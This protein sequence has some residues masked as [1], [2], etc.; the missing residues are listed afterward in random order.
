MYFC[1]GGSGYN[2]LSSRSLGASKL[3]T[4]NVM[5]HNVRSGMRA[6]VPRSTAQ[7]W[8]VRDP[9]KGFDRPTPKTPPRD[10]LDLLLFEQVVDQC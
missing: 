8:L 1:V 10:T 7:D 6:L 3:F 5:Y 2:R 4:I 9:E